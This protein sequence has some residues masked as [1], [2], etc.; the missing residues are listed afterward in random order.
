[1]FGK[2]MWTVV[3]ISILLGVNTIIQQKVAPIVADAQLRS[4]PN[5]SPVVPEFITVKPAGQEPSVST[6]STRT[7]ILT[8]N[9]LQN[10]L[11]WILTFIGILIFW[12]MWRKDI[13]K[14]IKFITE[15]SSNE[16]D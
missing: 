8:S 11:G 1:M 10:W 9:F 3:I 4:N 5:L 6:T 12:P 2:I 13:E 7:T 16:Q 14:G 15:G